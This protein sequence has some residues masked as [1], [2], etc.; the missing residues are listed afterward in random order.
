MRSR[1]STAVAIVSTLLAPSLAAYAQE[2]KTYV[3]KLSTARSTTSNT[4]G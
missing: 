2:D 3:M 4:N 1:Y